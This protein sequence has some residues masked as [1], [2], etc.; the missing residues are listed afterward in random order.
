MADEIKLLGVWASPF[1]RR[2]ELVLKLKGLQFE[3]SEEDLSNKSDLL[4]K[5]NPVH[6]KIPHSN[7]IHKKIPVLIHN[8][9]PISESLIILEYINETWNNN[10]NPLLPRD[11]HARSAARFWMKFV[12]E[13]IL[14]TSAKSTKT[15]DRGELEKIM[16]EV[17]QQLKLLEKELDGKEYFGG[18]T[19]GMLDVVVLMTVYWFE[20][21][22]ECMGV[23]EPSLQLITEEKIPGLVKWMRKL[24]T[25]DAVK[26]TLPP[27]EKQIARIRALVG[28]ENS[29]N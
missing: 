10:G 9:N 18:E 8:G 24:L 4:L 29:A 12:D 25:V 19:I 27:R 21:I 3:Y 11:P 1:S 23:V 20:L 6:K 13:T 28:A 15:R 16:E 14:P 17:N 5:S 7:P 22:Q 2:I 26:E